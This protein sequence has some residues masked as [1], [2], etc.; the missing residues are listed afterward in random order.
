MYELVHTYYIHIMYVRSRIVLLLLL[1]SSI[2]I[3]HTVLHHVLLTPEPVCIA[4][5]RALVLAISIL[6]ILLVVAMHSSTL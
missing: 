5:Q 4:V 3:I 6:C 1:A 2:S